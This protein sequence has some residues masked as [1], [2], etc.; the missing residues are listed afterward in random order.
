MATTFPTLLHSAVALLSGL[1]L[2]VAL[3]I[4]T[5][6]V[7]HALGVYPPWDEPMRDPW[8]NLL[9]LS[10]RCLYGVAG[11]YVAAALAPRALMGH[12]LALGAVGFVLSLFGLF[13]ALQL[14]LGPVWY[15]AALVLSTLPCAWLG[16][17]LRSRRGQHRARGRENGV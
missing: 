1:V 12:A 7:F 5:D 10:Y 9:A 8:L 3:S 13:A 17:A 4:G 2:I 6:Q 14:D 16:G 15:P 11:S